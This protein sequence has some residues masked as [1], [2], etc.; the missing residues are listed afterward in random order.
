[1]LIILFWFSVFLFILS[2]ICAVIHKTDEEQ[3]KSDE[4]QMK[5]IAHY[6]KSKS[7]NFHN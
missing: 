7:S 6:Q 5:F 4:E 2:I 1:M 3:K